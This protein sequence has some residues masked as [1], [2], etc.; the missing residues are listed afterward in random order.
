[1]ANTE[2]ASRAHQNNTF[3]KIELQSPADL[4]H[5]QTLSQRAARQKINVAFPPAAQEGGEDELRK[6]VEELVG[7]YVDEVFRGVKSNILVNGV[8]VTDHGDGKG[9]AREV[10]EGENIY[11]MDQELEL[12]VLG[13]ALIGNRIRAT[14]HTTCG[15]DTASRRTEREAYGKSCRS[16]KNRT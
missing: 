12:V 7:G 9:G 8:E 2:E 6:R 4:T 10:T 13:K 1:M 5:L 15:A 14:G 16:E 3:R 11:T